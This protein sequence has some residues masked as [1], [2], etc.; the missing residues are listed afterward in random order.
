MVLGH[1]AHVLDAFG[2]M[3]GMECW[4]ERNEAPLQLSP[5]ESLAS[6]SG[7]E[8]TPSQFEACQPIAS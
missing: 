7:P 5:A 1:G 2:G 4:L 6:E 3:H 8:S